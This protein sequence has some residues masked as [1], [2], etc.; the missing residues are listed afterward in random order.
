V[1]K[2]Q[3]YDRV[4]D[5]VTASPPPNVPG[6]NSVQIEGFDRQADALTLALSNHALPANGSFSLQ[7]NRLL[8][9]A[10]NA[11]SDSGRADP[12][13]N[14]FNDAI[15]ARYSDGV[16][17]SPYVRVRV[18]SFNRD[19]QPATSD[20]LPNWWMQQYFGNTTPAAAS[21]SRAQDDKDGDGL[22]NLEEWQAG[23]DPVVAGSSLRISGFDG[24]TLQFNARPY[25]L[26]E[27]VSSEDFSAW[28]R[29]ANPL[30]PT[31]TTGS[32]TGLESGATARFFQVRRV[33]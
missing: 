32:A 10:A 30:L 17:A 22:T 21:L 23:T 7:G 12:A 1:Y 8:Y 3:G 26:Y 27:V 16:N 33:P 9:T 20:G 6:I 5:V 4:I 14:A 24:S 18:L 13:G 19:T 28:S 2:R 31:V 25:D 11:W 15:F 29:A